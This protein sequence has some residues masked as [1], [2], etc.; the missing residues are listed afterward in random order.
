MLDLKREWSPPCSS[1]RSSEGMPGFLDACDGTL[2]CAR[3]RHSTTRHRLQRPAATRCSWREGAGASRGKRH[4]GPAATEGG[5]A[6]AKPQ[7]QSTTAARRN[8]RAGGRAAFD[9]STRP[10]SR[11]VGEAKRRLK[12]GT[13]GRQ[14]WCDRQKH[15]SSSSSPSSPPPPPSQKLRAAL[16]A[17]LASDLTG[18]PF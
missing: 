2:A 4:A 7:R 10:L 1:S 6:G 5:R 17:A 15:S 13:I 8:E 12:H 11:V 3:A 18:G 16:A 9:K 14:Y